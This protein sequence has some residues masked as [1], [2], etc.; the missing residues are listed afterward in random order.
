M[1]SKIAVEINKKCVLLDELK[2]KGEGERK[3]S[4]FEEIG[5]KQTNAV[6]SAG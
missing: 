5:E 4:S 1:F 3:K 6:S 2:G